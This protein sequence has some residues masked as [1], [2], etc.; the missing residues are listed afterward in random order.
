FECAR[1]P[2]EAE[3]REDGWGCLSE[4]EERTDLASVAH[5]YL[6][7][8]RGPSVTNPTQLLCK[9]PDRQSGHSVSETGHLEGNLCN[10]SNRRG[11]ANVSVFL[12]RTARQLSVS[13]VRL[14][15]RLFHPYISHIGACGAQ[16][17]G[18]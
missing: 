3:T 9:E 7:P 8:D 6:I 14:P 5:P 1:S 13:V 4:R 10:R 17:R 18:R 15:P 12:R 16:L 11:G 2:L